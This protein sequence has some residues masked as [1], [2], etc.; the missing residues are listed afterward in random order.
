MFINLELFSNSSQFSFPGTGQHII[1][2]LSHNQRQFSPFL[3]CIASGLS[4]SL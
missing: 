2:I 3:F 4:V 1:L